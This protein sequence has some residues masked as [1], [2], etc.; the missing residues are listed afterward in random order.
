MRASSPIRALVIAVAVALAAAPAI[1]QAQVYLGVTIDTPPPLIPTYT[2]PPAPYPNYMWE[3]GFWQW[4]TAGYFWVPG[5]WTAPPATGLYW[6]PGYWGAS[7]PGWA[8]HPG[9]WGPQVGFYG[10]INYGYGY[11]GSGFVGGYWSGNAFRYNTA[12]VNVNRTVIHNTY[13]NKTV[14]RNVTNRVSY[15]GGRGGI[16]RQPTAAEQR[17]YAQRRYGPTQAQ[18]DHS[19]SASNDREAAS[20]VNHGKPARTATATPM[21]HRPPAAKMPTAADKKAAQAHQT[22]TPREPTI[23]DSDLGHGPPP[24]HPAPAPASGGGHKPP[25]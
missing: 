6:T 4:G 24:A 7:G 16:V 15:N 17:A 23:H 1:S 13:V 9:W 5:T 20:A 25:L 21:P 18:L 19:R 10:G 12:V 3:P 8:W 11:Y 2:Q 14:V 22:G